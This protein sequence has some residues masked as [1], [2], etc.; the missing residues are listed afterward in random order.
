M[1][2]CCTPELSWLPASPF[3]ISS[4][5]RMQGATRSAASSASRIRPSDSPR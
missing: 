2:R 3:S 1:M 5:H 4:I